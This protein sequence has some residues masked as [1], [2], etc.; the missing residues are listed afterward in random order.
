MSWNNIVPAE[1][2]SKGITTTTPLENPAVTIPLDLLVG[3]SI[4]YEIEGLYSI[5][6][7]DDHPAFAELRKRLA[8]LH[9]IEIPDY[10]CW[11]GDRV[12]KRFRFN[13]IQLEPGDTFYCAAAWQY[14]KKDMK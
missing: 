9:L 14:H 1:L 8:S 13:G 12:L 7:T 2:L 5:V 3:C 4:K 11:N 6:G 10:A